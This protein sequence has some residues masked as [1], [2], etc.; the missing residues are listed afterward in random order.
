MVPLTLSSR[1]RLAFSIPNQWVRRIRCGPG[2]LLRAS[3]ALTPTAN[4]VS[5]SVN[6]TKA[7]N[8][9][10]VETA[11]CTLFEKLLLPA[12]F[13]IMIK[14]RRE[15]KFVLSF[16]HYPVLFITTVLSFKRAQVRNKKTSCFLHRFNFASWKYGT[17]SNDCHQPQSF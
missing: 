1:G 6:H 17:R 15:F 2:I 3:S 8:P 7:S 9:Y 5:L 14:I 13:Y 16:C 4:M 11:R 10:P 12:N